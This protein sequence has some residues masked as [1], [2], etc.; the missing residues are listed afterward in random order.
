MEWLFYIFTII[1]A[2]VLGSIPTSVWIG[3]YFH[4]IDVREHGSG[5][6]GATNTVRVLGWRA[7]LPVLLIDMIKGL[8]AVSLVWFRQDLFPSPDFFVSFQL[9]LGVAAMLGHI[10]PVFARFKGGKGVATLTGVAL[11]VQPWATLSCFGVFMVFLLLF[12]Y[13]SLGSIAAGIAFPL[14]V[15]F[16][17]Q[18]SYLALVLFSLAIA[19]IIIVTH[20]KNIRRLLQGEESK[21]DFLFKKKKEG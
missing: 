9:I 15:I 5:N 8:A 20:H 6:A 2:Y 13:V 10:F 17:F 12:R 11:A 19:I 7:G 16:V 18:T 3:K 14:F 1:L 21:A 4:G